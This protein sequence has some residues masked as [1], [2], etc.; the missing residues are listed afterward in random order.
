MKLGEKVNVRGLGARKLL[1][2]AHFRIL[3]VISWT[4][5]ADSNACRGQEHLLN[6]GYDT[7]QVEESLVALLQS[8]TKCRC[9]RLSPATKE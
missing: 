7:R 4:G 2:G 8:S 1:H 5:A 9:A 3:V 6:G